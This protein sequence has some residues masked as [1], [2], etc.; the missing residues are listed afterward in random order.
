MESS[1]KSPLNVI[2]SRTDQ[3]DRCKQA[4]SA[5]VEAEDCMVEL[6]KRP[7]NL[8][9]FLIDL[10]FIGVYPEPLVNIPEQLVIYV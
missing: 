4:A 3:W 9:G 8:L 1:R 5:L 10:S 7:R 6:S 2:R